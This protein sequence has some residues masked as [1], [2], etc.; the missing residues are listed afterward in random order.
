MAS[1]RP[2][3]HE[4]PARPRPH[5]STA[6]KGLLS[7]LLAAGRTLSGISPRRVESVA[8]DLKL[9]RALR[10]PAGSATLLPLIRF[11][12]RSQLSTDASPARNARLHE[13]DGRQAGSRKSDAF[14]DLRVAFG[15]QWYL[16]G[17][18]DRGRLGI[19]PSQVSDAITEVTGPLVPSR[20]VPV[21]VMRSPRTSRLNCPAALT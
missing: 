21:P 14:V 12:S 8:V 11:R 2:V 17:A 19:G 3:G 4:F 5:G 18:H 7:L 13:D 9:W 20:D 16:R 15:R 6:R 1:K 10:A